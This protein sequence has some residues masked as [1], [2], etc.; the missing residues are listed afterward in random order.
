MRPILGV[1][2]IPARYS[3][4]A[5][6]KGVEMK[7]IAIGTWVATIGL[8]IV[9]AA[10]ADGCLPCQGGTQNLVPAG[11]YHSCQRKPPVVKNAI[12]NF[13]HQLFW[14]DVPYPGCS[15]SELQKYQCKRY[16]EQVADYYEN[17]SEYVSATKKQIGSKKCCKSPCQYPLPG[18]WVSGGFLPSHGVSGHP[19][20]WSAGVAGPSTG[21][22]AYGDRQ[23]MYEPGPPSAARYIETAGRHANLVR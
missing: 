17:V 1:P 18:G 7:R 9:P 2:A 15:M 19:R 23:M 12:C 10:R 20:G 22:Y 11:C 14:N 5:G 16:Y 6:M 3:R 8:L 21:A 4:S 13:T